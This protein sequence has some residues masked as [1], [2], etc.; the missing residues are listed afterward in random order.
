M[1][2]VEEIKEEQCDDA[3]RRRKRKPRSGMKKTSAILV[4]T[5][6]VWK[7]RKRK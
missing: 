7:R 6:E 1:S 4:E 3:W 5:R 2:E